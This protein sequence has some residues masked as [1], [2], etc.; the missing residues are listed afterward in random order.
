MQALRSYNCF[1]AMRFVGFADFGLFLRTRGRG[2]AALSFVD[3]RLSGNLH[4]ARFVDPYNHIYI[5]IY[6]MTACLE[7]GSNT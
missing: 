3:S 1:D 5:H 6:T 7:A 2:F 4:H